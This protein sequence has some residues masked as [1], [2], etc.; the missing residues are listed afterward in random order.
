MGSPL[1]VAP[2]A[3]QAAAAAETAVGQAIVGLDVGQPL[4]AAATA[5]PA[6]Q[7]GAACAQV[8]PVVDGAAR[9]IGSEVDAHAAKL[10]SA[11]QRYQNTDDVSAG[12]LNSAGP[13][14]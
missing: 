5:M 1:K 3:L 13:M 11:A 12:R 10:S 9:A 6:L 7:S 14:G 8:A 4:S 2:E